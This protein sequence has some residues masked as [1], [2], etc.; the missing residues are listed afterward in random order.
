MSP[1]HWLLCGAI[2]LALKIHITVSLT[3]VGCLVGADASPHHN[4]LFPWY[5]YITFSRR[6]AMCRRTTAWHPESKE[7]EGTGKGRH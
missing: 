5:I 3:I 6:D 7:Q 2:L 4:H 1:R